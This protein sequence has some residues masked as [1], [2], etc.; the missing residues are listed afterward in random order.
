[1]KG[2]IFDIKHYA[3][4][5]GPGIRQ[6]VFFKGCPLSC[7]WCHNPESQAPRIETYIKS[8]NLDGHTHRRKE[9]T[10]HY[11]ESKELFKVIE[12]DTVF[13]DESGGGVT[14]SGGEPLMQQEFLKDVARQCKQT[15]I[16]TALDTCGYADQQVFFQV[17]P[18]MDL[19]LYDLKI[20]DDNLHQKYTGASNK[21]IL[22]NLELLDQTD[23]V[24]RLR[25]PVIPG[26]TD[27]DK[28]LEDIQSYLS[29]LKRINNI[30]ILSYHEMSKTKYERFGKDNKMGDQKLE[31]GTMDNIRKRFE[32]MG[33]HVNINA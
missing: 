6:T 30:D 21:K 5:D 33:F 13:Y 18:F 2:L 12:G 10:G 9:E 24:T 31:G 16:H 7:W 28:N 19:I 27:T 3:I 8:K 26:I 4:H 23:K 1:M 20:I 29:T 17:L 22:E 15:E 14:F 25:F 11:T 32:S